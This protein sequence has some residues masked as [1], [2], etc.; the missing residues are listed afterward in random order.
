MPKAGLS[1][2]EIKKPQDDESPWWKTIDAMHSQVTV[3]VQ[4]NHRK[5]K[6]VTSVSYKTTHQP[7]AP[8]HVSLPRLAQQEQC[9]GEQAEARR[10]RSTHRLKE[11]E[12]ERR[13][14]RKSGRKRSRKE[15]LWMSQEYGS[16]T[17]TQIKDVLMYYELWRHSEDEQSR[18]R[19]EERWSTAAAAEMLRR[20]EPQDVKY[21]QL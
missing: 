17:H 7:Y 6:E 13:D 5:L 19:W 20:S 4:V 12:R 15:E 21:Q 10:Q 11:G 3:G 1:M 16:E 14:R 2:T 8:D 9:Q 18:S